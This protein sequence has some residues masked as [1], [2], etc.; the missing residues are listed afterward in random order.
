[1]IVEYRVLKFES[2]IKL[3]TFMERMIKEGWEPC[4][5]IAFNPKTERYIQ[6]IVKSKNHE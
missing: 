1:M 2:T 3:E 5:G 4:G 6:A